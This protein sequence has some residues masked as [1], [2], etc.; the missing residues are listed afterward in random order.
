MTTPEQHDA[1]AEGRLDAGL[2]H[3][4]VRPLPDLTS[5]CLGRDPFWAAVPA[6]HALAGRRTLRFADI[7]GEP[8][9]LFPDSQG[10]A[11]HATIRALA[12]QTSGALRVVAEASRVHSQ[13]AIISGGLGVGLITQATAASLTVAGVVAVPL[14]DTGDRLFL[15]LHLMAEP[16]LAR[17]LSDMIGGILAGR[18]RPT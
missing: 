8:F 3:P 12:E 5:T 10:P 16:A 2:L 4:P 15:E 7:A 18:R 6:D 11:L 17:E 13:L 9:V 14:A 1:L